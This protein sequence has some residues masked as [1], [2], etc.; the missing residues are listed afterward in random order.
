MRRNDHCKN[1][2]T[3]HVFVQKY[4]GIR[5][6]EIGGRAADSPPLAA[7]L[8]ARAHGAHRGQKHQARKGES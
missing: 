4:C 2:S 5:L 7:L 3:D 1:S 6:L 8:V